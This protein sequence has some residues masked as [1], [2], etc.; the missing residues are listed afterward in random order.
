M[1]PFMALLPDGPPQQV[2]PCPR[3]RLPSVE[4]PA[5]E[6]DPCFMA[7]SRFECKPGKHALLKRLHGL[8]READSLP[9][10]TLLNLT[11]AWLPFR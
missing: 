10:F 2:V 9:N 4:P 6:G 8:P 3:H 11:L 7:P 5:Q 1:L